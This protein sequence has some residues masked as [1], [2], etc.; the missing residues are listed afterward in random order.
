MTK[1]PEGNFLQGEAWR[2]VNELEGCK[3][4]R[5]DFDGQ[6]VCQMIVRNAK[7]GRYLEIPGGPLLDWSDKKLKKRV[8]AKI[9]E[10]AEAEKCVFVRMRP[11][12]PNTAENC[13]ILAD[14][15]AKKAPMHLAAEH[16]IALDLTRSEDE[17]LTNMRRQ[18]RY[19]VRKAEKLGLTV[20]SDDSEAIF[21]EF[22]Q[23][24]QKT[25]ARQHFY[26]PSRDEL[27]AERRG[28]NDLK[29]RDVSARIFTAKSAEGKPV[30]YG[31]ILRDGI[32]ADYYEAAST[33]LNREL[34]GAY[35]LQWEVMK[36]LKSEGA[37]RYNLWGIAP[38]GEPNHRYAKVTTFKRGFGGE[39][40]NFVPA[41]DIVI[42]PVR[43]AANW[44]FENLRKHHR[45]LG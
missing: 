44:L 30:A 34:P 7:R 38:E 17:L 1:F 31:L 4:I 27:Q 42:K 33:D 29:K 11:Q 13:Q 10:V 36:T 24:Q 32:E 18:T 9:R 35:K 5:E 39:M 20:T 45:H 21:D 37:K 40:V 6:A 19:E 3:V 14:L 22:Y 25:A 26:A 23:V 8:F 2:K 43:Y 15:G 16:T 41:H 28:F 12:L